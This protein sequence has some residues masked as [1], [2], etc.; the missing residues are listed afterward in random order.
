MACG[1]RVENTHPDGGFKRRRQ[2]A[3]QARC[4]A[5]GRPA[6]ARRRREQR[7]RVRVQRPREDALLRALLHREP[8]VHHEHLVRDVA[9][10]AEVVRDEEIGHAEL[11]L[12][13]GQQVQHLRLH[14]D[15][16][17]RHRLVGHD[18]R[19]LEHQRARDRDALPLAAREH[20]RIAIVVLG[21]QADLSEHRPRA[22]GA[23]CRRESR[24]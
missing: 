21:P 22:L 4:A 11:A 6:S 9:H 3:F 23:R 7:L 5:C 10:H 2:F 15:V 20:V 13:V 14:R 1:Q 16:E 19:G 12:Q 18:E 17:R 8:E 24:C